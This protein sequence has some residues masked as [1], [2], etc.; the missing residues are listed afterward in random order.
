[1]FQLKENKIFVNDPNFLPTRKEKIC[2]S[3]PSLEV[4]NNRAPTATDA[5]EITLRS[6]HAGDNSQAPFLCLRVHH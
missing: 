5:M 3:S 1:M 4:F 2:L 6:V